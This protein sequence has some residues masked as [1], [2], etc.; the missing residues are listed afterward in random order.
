M[1][2]PALA[3]GH[4]SALA[5]GPP[6][7]SRSPFGRGPLLSHQR[8]LGFGGF[9]RPS[10]SRL[11]PYRALGRGRVPWRGAWSRS[12][13]LYEGWCPAI[14]HE[15]GV[16]CQL[17]HVRF[18]LVRAIPASRVT[19]SASSSR[20]YFRFVPEVGFP[21][22]SY[23]RG[24]FEAVS[25]A[26]AATSAVRLV[27]PLAD[28]V[29]NSVD[30]TVLGSGFPCDGTR[31]EVVARRAGATGAS[32]VRRPLSTGRLVQARQV[33]DE[34]SVSAAQGG[35]RFGVYTGP[36][37]TQKIAARTSSALAGAVGR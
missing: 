3:G 20:R 4:R 1:Q 29:R 31:S 9:G 16:S 32:G 26:P 27:H 13:R 18:G 35:V 19:G 12:G 22:R 25:S 10:G 33:D 17:D 23:K 5:S 14:V 7:L 6:R 21:V 30:G 28:V 34:T 37:Q 36:M 15:N 11:R 2:H 24:A 8:H